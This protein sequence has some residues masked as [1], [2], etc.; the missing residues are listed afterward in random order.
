MSSALQLVRFIGKPAVPW[1]ASPGESISSVY[2][3]ARPTDAVY[4][5]FRYSPSSI[6]S[7]SV[8]PS[9]KTWS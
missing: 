1:C 7:G 6:F 5:D 8:S 3:V 9:L 4:S 2:D